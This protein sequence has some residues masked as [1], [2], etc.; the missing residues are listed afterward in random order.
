M[1]HENVFAND[2]QYLWVYLYPGEVHIVD[3]E[4]IGER[5]GE[6]FVGDVAQGDQDLAKVPFVPFLDL[7][8]LLE[9]LRVELLHVDLAL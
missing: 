4:L 8:S 1:A 2:P 3:A 9:L 5:P 6:V 7:Q